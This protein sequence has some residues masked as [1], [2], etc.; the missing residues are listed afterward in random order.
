MKIIAVYT[1]FAAVSL[2]KSVTACVE[3]NHS[4]FYDQDW[5]I[6]AVKGPNGE[7]VG[8]G[9]HFYSNTAAN[10]NNQLL[11]QVSSGLKGRKERTITSTTHFTHSL[12]LFRAFNQSGTHRIRQTLISDSTSWILIRV[13]YRGTLVRKGSRS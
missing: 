3:G 4:A 2:F 11:F 12:A 6:E 13:C 5:T 8:P 9:W 1:L 7:L 10:L